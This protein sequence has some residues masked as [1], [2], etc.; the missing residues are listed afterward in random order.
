MVFRPQSPH[1]LNIDTSSLHIN[2]NGHKIQEVK[3]TKF[4]GVTIDEYLSWKYHVNE[5]ACKISKVTGV[6]NRLKSF[7]PLSVLVNLYNTM[8]LPHISYCIVI[9]GKC[10]NYL[11]DRIFILQKRAIRIIT[12][13]HFLTSTDRLFLKT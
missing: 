1:N 8:I 2:L 5:I 3:F 11:L 7:L 6:L 9:W 10:A 12:N 13:S 4:L